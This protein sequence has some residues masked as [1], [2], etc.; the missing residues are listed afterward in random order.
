MT[1]PLGNNL[2]ILVYTWIFVSLPPTGRFSQPTPFAHARPTQKL[3][4]ILFST[5]ISTGNTLFLLLN[6]R[7]RSVEIAKLSC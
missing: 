7:Q 5:R 6:C 2:N 4:T 1:S 3:I